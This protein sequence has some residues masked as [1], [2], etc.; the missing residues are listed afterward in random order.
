VPGVN[1][2]LL[3][4]GAAAAVLALAGC[5]APA[6]PG[7][8][9]IAADAAIPKGSGGLPAPSKGAEATPA[10]TA[11]VS[12][13]STTL[14]KATIPLAGVAKTTK[15]DNYL[16]LT[17]AGDS[18]CSLE[19]IDVGATRRAGGSV[20]TPAP[21]LDQGWWWGSD[22]ASCGSG[23]DTSPITASTVVD[24]GYKKVGPK[25]AV[26][27]SWR[28]TCQNSALDFD[29]RLWWLPTSQIAFRAHSTAGGSGAA[30]DKVL[31]GITFGA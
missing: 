22:A 14:G 10:P 24:K 13:P 16:C 7:H 30:V 27:G 28:V 6:V 8:G 21:G 5:G 9:R 15:Q 25:T 18:G 12:G 11:T 17:V 31:A 23:S 1:R 20:S 2:V 4:A 3:A 19:I 29:P 26:Y